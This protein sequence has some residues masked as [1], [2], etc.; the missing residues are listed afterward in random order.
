[1]SREIKFRVWNE[2]LEEMYELRKAN[3][4][5]STGIIDSYIGGD[6]SIWQQYTGLK[7]TNGV[8]IYEG[9]ILEAADGYKGVIEYH[10]LRAQFVGRNVGN[11]FFDEEFDTLYTNDGNFDSAKV[12]G[13]I[14]EN[15]NLLEEK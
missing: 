15:K 2:E 9:D 12:I 7:D 11:K 6:K 13:N 8:D 14:Y 10:S 5:G 1:M 4:L 3:Y